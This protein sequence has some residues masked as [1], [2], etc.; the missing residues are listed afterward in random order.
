[1]CGSKIGKKPGL[2]Q[3]TRLVRG[4]QERSKFEETSEALYLTSGYVYGTAEEA[5]A[6][7]EAPSKRRVTSGAPVS[8]WLIFSIGRAVARRLS[9][10]TR[11]STSV[12]NRGSSPRRR[13]SA[14]R[15]SSRAKV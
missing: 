5:E 10:S 8:N 7:F 2:R 12:T 3:Q 15:A 6:A 13:A 11:R 4:G 1:M 9:A 14:W